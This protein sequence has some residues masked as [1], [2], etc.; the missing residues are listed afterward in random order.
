M[1]KEGIDRVSHP[2]LTSEELLR[3]VNLTAD[4]IKKPAYLSNESESSDVEGNIFFL[5]PSKTKI[6]KFHRH[7]SLFN[8]IKNL[9]NSSSFLIYFRIAPVKDSLQEEKTIV[10]E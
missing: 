7:L 6:F 2:G 3:Q 1:I 4:S 5:H 10:R 9:T 8:K